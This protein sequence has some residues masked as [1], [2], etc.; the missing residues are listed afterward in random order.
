VSHNDRTTDRGGHASANDRG[1]CGVGAL[2]DKDT[3]AVVQ[4]DID[5]PGW[6]AL[7]EPGLA[8]LNL[9]DL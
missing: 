1:I 6:R 2:P 3:L 5:V 7:Q 4:T 9:L 8:E